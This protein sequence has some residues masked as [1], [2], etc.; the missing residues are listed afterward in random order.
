M[1]TRAETESRS[2]AIQASVT[3]TIWLDLSVAALVLTAASGVPGLA[4]GRR[5]NAAQGLASLLVI[6]GALLGEL[7]A[8]AVLGGAAIET[9]TL[10]GPLSELSLHL[11]LDP[12]AAFFLVPVY[13]LSV[14]GT[15]YGTR[16]W[17]QT[18]H[19]ENGRAL[20]LWYGVLVAALAAV[21]LA[22]DGFAFLMAWEVM[23]LAAFFLVT[24]EDDRAEVRQAGWVYLVATHAGTLALFALFALLWA[25]NGSLEFRPMAS[26]AGTQGATSALFLLALVGFGFK[27]GIVPLHFWLPAAHANAPSHVSALMSGLLLKMG[28]YGLLRFFTLLPAPPPGVG[29]LMI[30][31]GTFSAVYGVVF[32]LGQHDLKR[33]LAYHSIENIGIIVMGMGLALVGVSAQQPAWVA[34]GLA[35]C[36]LHVWNHSF[37][38]GLLFLAAGSVIHGAGTREID[39]LGGLGKPMSRTAALFAIGAVA[40][41]GLPPLNGF[42]SELLIYVGLFRAG[43]DGASRQW[44]AAPLAA[45]LLAMVGALAVACFV[46]AYG[47]VFL[48]PHR[49]EG[50][51]RAHEV[52]RSMLVAMILLALPCVAIGV[53]PVLAMPA[54]DRVVHAW[55]GAESQ[56][57]L[58]GHLIPWTPIM[59]MNAALVAGVLA[60]SLILGRRFRRRVPVQTGTW[61]CGYVQP[62]AAM[63]YSAS[64]FAQLLVDLYGW[65]LRPRAGH[66]I[67]T[68]L[69]PSR[70]HFH[71]R[72]PEQVTEF[73]LAPL[74]V[75]FRRALAPFRALQH[76]RVQLYLMYVLLTLCILVVL[77]FPI[78]EAFVRFLGW[79]GN[80]G[81]H[82][83]E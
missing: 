30:A 29:M 53:F 58:L 56:P 15:L 76:G 22:A 41:C 43:A 79:W 64:S 72:V 80:G 44:S 25:V 38:K 66:A 6:A 54:L 74:W 14:A 57:P 52:P 9:R 39:R 23:A 46:K 82:G 51:A 21:V 83:V 27:A 62:T 2:I 47:T 5:S 70:Q 49:S 32:A 71:T 1:R 59:G 16:Y 60:V 45:P 13:L 78:D 48:G 81:V 73:V 3:Q 26:G 18:E 55:V 42:V 33:L 65:L 69:F 12:L 24:I 11:R 63:S 19:P 77:S 40:I 7:A 10:P 8:I 28:I 75:S 20:R 37:F 67:R 17:K 31:I 34:L 68:E 35:G 36:L 50:A 61:D 4:L